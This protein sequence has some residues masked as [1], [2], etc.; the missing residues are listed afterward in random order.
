MD[1]NNTHHNF[2]LDREGCIE[3]GNTPPTKTRTMG[4]QSSQ[5]ILKEKLM[6]IANDRP[7]TLVFMIKYAS[8]R[9]NIVRLRQSVKNT[10]N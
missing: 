7:E 9:T 1:L 3:K 6:K 2:K 4:E 10:H 8:Q 5:H